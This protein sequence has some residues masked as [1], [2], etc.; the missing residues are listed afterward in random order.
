[1]KV[2]RDA[3]EARPYSITELASLYKMTRKTMNK[4]LM[5]HAHLIG[6]RVGRFY[7]VKQVLLIFE[8][9]DLPCKVGD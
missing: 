3:I 9:I 5:P 8:L 6:K 2:T 4:W 1:M 7:N